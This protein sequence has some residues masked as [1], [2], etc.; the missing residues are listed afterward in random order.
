MLELVPLCTAVVEVAPP[1]A[2]GN[3]P[4]GMRSVGHFNAVTIEGERMRATLASPAG[5]DWM[6]INGTIGVIDVRL[7]VRTDDGALVHISYGGRL[8]LA[9]RANGLFAHVAPTFE[10]GDERYAWLNAVQAVGKG[11]L[12]PGEGGATRIDY[13]FYQIR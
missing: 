11:K 3:G 6:A 2:V 9:D 12:T 1:L 4:A 13:E 7:T 10:T 8:N 5:A